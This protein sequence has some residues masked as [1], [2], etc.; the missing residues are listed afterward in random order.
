[1]AGTPRRTARLQVVT[2]RG[3]LCR[4]RIGDVVQCV[5]F[6]GQSPIIRFCYR[7]GQVSLLQAEGALD[8]LGCCE[9]IS[10]KPAV[11]CLFLFHGPQPSAPLGTRRGQNDAARAFCTVRGGRAADRFLSRWASI[12]KGSGTFDSQRQSGS[13]EAMGGDADSERS[14]PAGSFEGIVAA[15]D[16]AKDELNT[17]AWRNRVFRLARRLSLT[18]GPKFCSVAAAWCI[19]GETWAHLRR[20]LVPQPAS[21]HI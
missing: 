4:W 17:V 21:Q 13:S 14:L 7:Q 11:A 5:G 2:T 16:V 19:G 8:G 20:L 6:E 15:A 3:G 18:T 1:M 9:D 10:A 12:G